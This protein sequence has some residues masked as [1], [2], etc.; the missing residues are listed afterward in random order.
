MLIGFH[1]GRWETVYAIMSVVRRSDGPGGNT[2]VP[3]DRYSLTM[4]FWVVP[5]SLV[6]SAPC[7]SATTW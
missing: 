1:F 6:M 3:R 2:W 7:S 5:W 4:S